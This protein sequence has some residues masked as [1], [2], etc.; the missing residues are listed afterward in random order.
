MNRAGG[1]QAFWLADLKVT[2]PLKC[3]NGTIWL[4]GH[5]KQVQK[6]AL[7]KPFLTFAYVVCI[8]TW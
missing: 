2:F 3:M 7:S 6:E 1:K 8:K 5:K 4:Y